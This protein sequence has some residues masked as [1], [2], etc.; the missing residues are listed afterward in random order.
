[1][2]LTAQRIHDGRR[3]LPQ[4]TIIETDLQ[5]TVLSVYQ[6]TDRTGV[7]VYDGILCPGFVNAHCH[8]ELSHMKGF[9][10]EHTGLIP[11]LKHIPT[12]RN[13]FT[14]EQKTE[15]RHAAYHQMVANGIVAVGDIGNTSDTLDLRALDQLHV[16]SF[17]EGLGFSQQPQAAYEYVV[18]V[19]D[20]LKEQ[21]VKTRMLRQSIVP[22]APYTV[23]REFFQLIDQHEPTAVLSV[24]NQEAWAENQ[25]YI[26]KEGLVPELLQLFHIDD[27][28]FQ[29][30]GKTSLQTYVEWLSHTHPV[31]FIHNTYTAREDV[32]AAHAYLPDAWWCLCPNAN[33]YI[34]ETLPNIDLFLEEQA[35]IC[36]GTDSLA[37]NHKLDILAELTTIKEHYPKLS[38]EE[39]LQWG[40]LNGARALQMEDVIGSIEVGKQ[41]GIVQV[42]GLDTDDAKP[43]RIL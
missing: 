21:G 2:L 28:F 43:N 31:L 29:P 10:P 8:M 37:S 13:T 24:H 5:G 4:N 14:P 22:H 32:Q 38:W 3:W 11:F 25:Y 19:H 1:M 40:T 23:S 18:K 41:P 39:L 9:I 42:T 30:S 26:S 34:E 20:A 6:S 7:T 27:S 35:N 36:V 33:L 15:A 16:H 12:F 17:V